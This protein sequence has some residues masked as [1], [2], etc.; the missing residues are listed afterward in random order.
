[1]KSEAKSYLLIWQG[2][3]KNYF[4]KGTPTDEEISRYWTYLYDSVIW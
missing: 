2:C 1:M 3:D 4:Y